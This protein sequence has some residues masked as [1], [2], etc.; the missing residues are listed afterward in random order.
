MGTIVKIRTI[1][2][3]TG[4][5]AEYG[6]LAPVIDTINVQRGLRLRL[7]V[8]GVHLSTGT[9][10]Q[11]THRIDAKAP[12]Q[13]RGET[14]RDADVAALGRGV[15][16][17]GIAF[18]QLRPD[19]VL[20]L[21]DRVEIFAAASAASVGGYRVAHIHGGDR[22]EGVADEA[23]RHATSK[24]AHLHFAASA[25]SR[26][27]LIRMGE[28]SRFVFNVGSPAVAGLSDVAAAD[29]DVLRQVGLDPAKPYVVI[30][31]HPIGDS[32]A[33]ERR[34]MLAILSATAKYQRVVMAPNHD[35]GRDGIMRAI[36][37]SRIEP[38]THLPRPQF[39][40]LL[41]RCDMLLGNSSAGLIEASAVKTGGAR[42]INIG[43]RQ[44]GRERPSNVIDCRANARSIR[45]AM[46][47]TPRPCRHPYGK[48]DA[49]P[50]IADILATIDLATVPL[51]KQ[52]A[53]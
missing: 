3:V 33:N 37:D 42:V 4:T 11:I 30:M 18:A 16:N 44:G 36:T 1:A 45:A 10:K 40:G 7:V 8:G 2:V 46:C 49:P 47:K 14:G 38:I 21:G 6:L 27:R 23:M 35:P 19:V 43:P 48:G 50:R 26:R 15:I 24:L 12:M 25:Q 41:K 52:N 39:L 9:W 28:D 53:Y 29:D 51:R 17:F 22:A 31:H 32:A 34:T 5:R 13:K 20:V